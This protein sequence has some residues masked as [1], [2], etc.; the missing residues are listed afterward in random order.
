MEEALRIM[1]KWNDVAMIRSDNG[2]WEV[3]VL[4]FI[5]I[6]HDIAN[7][8]ESEK[9]PP[10]QLKFYND[11]SDTQIRSLSKFIKHRTCEYEGYFVDEKFVSL[12]GA[13]ELMKYLSGKRIV[14]MKIPKVA[15]VLI[16]LA[17]DPPYVYNSD[18]SD[19]EF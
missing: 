13:F 10:K 1:P 9:L 5:G 19:D 17:N 6:L 2:E 18:D 11:L 16:H 8:R 3:S 15:Q 14:D 7:K 12:T 4:D